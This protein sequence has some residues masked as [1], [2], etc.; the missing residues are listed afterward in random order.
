MLS[1]LI[2]HIHNLALFGGI[3]SVV[4]RSASNRLLPDLQNMRFNFLTN[5]TIIQTY[6][7]NISAHLHEIVS[8]IMQDSYRHYWWGG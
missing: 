4:S 5:D 1:I 7:I 6:V 3:N 8:I 2:K